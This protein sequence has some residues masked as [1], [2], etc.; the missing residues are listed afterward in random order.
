MAKLYLDVDGVLGPFGAPVDLMHLEWGDF[1]DASHNDTRFYLQLSPSMAKAL[2]DVVDGDICWLT[3]WEAN[4]WCNL[5][6]A[7]SLEWCELPV[8]ER[9]GTQKFSGYIEHYKGVW[10]KFGALREHDP[11][12]KFV[13]IDDELDRRIKN[14]SELAHWLNERDALAISPDPQVG[15]TK[16]HIEQIREFFA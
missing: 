1:A 7:P 11:K 12:G 13:W 9:K 16:A 15:I 3:T 4:N 2:W 14:E 10:W 8:L 5:K 6:V